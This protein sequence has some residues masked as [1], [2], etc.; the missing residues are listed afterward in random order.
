M[1]LWGAAVPSCS[2]RTSWKCQTL[3]LL[4]QRWRASGVTVTGISLPSSG[5]W[6]QP[7]A[8]FRAQPDN[9]SAP[10]SHMHTKT[11]PASQLPGHSSIACFCGRKLLDPVSWG[12]TPWQVTHCSRFGLKWVKSRRGNG[13]ND[14]N[15]MIDQ[16]IHLSCKITGKFQA[17]LFVLAFGLGKDNLI[18]FVGANLYLICVPA[19]R[20]IQICSQG[21]M[22]DNHLK[23]GRDAFQKENSWHEKHCL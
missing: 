23:P 3:T 1:T 19:G 11:T 21:L 7:S 10:W 15:D 17:K 4:S 12:T 8:G 6:R 5:F 16:V 14:R 9:L 18:V 2:C 13:W 22:E 20:K